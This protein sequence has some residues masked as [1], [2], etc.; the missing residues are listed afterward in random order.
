[1]PSWTV[2]CSD[3]A[4]VEG[5]PSLKLDLNR[6]V[7]LSRPDSEV[8]DI[9]VTEVINGCNTDLKIQIDLHYTC[10][11]SFY[12]PMPC[13]AVAALIYLVNQIQWSALLF[14]QGLLWH[15]SWIY[16]KQ[17]IIWKQTTFHWK[18]LSNCEQKRTKDFQIFKF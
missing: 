3:C 6:K 1:M 5:W 12:L 18:V 4:W 13:R 8:K 9:K 11:N 16:Q 14:W 10:P 7:I 17:F 2:L 15:F